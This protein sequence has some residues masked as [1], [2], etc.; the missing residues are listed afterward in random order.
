MDVGEGRGLVGR[1][2]KGEKKRM[3]LV[4]KK[5]E[6][7]LFLPSTSFPFFLWMGDSSTPRVG[8]EFTLGSPDAYCFVFTSVEHHLFVFL[9]SQIWF[10]T[11]S[12]TCSVTEK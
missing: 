2:T 9:L 10:P 12:E 3:S 7:C 6:N 8:A 1:S 4:R 5:M 11:A